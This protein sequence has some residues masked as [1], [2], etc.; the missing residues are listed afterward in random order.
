M[1]VFASHHQEMLENGLE[2]T[3][4][5]Q[6]AAARV[7]STVIKLK[8]LTIPYGS[9]SIALFLISGAIQDLRGCRFS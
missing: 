2:S 8:K 5:Y 9:S 3:F 7:F 6:R 1:A 4:M